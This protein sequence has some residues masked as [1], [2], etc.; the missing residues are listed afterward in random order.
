M[1]CILCIRDG[2]WLKRHEDVRETEKDLI[3]RKKEEER[4]RKAL[5]N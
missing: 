1:R 3:S 5:G 2:K 4:Q